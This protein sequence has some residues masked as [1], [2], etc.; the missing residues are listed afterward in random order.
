MKD[1]NDTTSGNWKK[2]YTILILANLGYILAFYF[3]MQFFS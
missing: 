2:E 3:I 1:H